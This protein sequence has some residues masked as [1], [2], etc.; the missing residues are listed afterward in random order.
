VCQLWYDLERAALEAVGH[1]GMTTDA[2]HGRVHFKMS[3][4][5]L[6]CQLP[7]GR[8][9]CYPYARIGEK[10]TWWGQIKDTVLYKAVDDRTKQWGETFTY[11]G[12]LTENIVQAIARDILADAL[13]R[14]SA[15]SLPVVCHVHDE[16]VCEVPDTDPSVDELLVH[17]RQQPAWSAGLPLAVE[18]WAGVRYR[19]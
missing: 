5:F 12:K 9:L 7:S 14:V 10:E 11:G 3:G 13:V 6:F 8:C 2:A 19:K 15:A 18:G 1:P 4:S 17:M 16:I